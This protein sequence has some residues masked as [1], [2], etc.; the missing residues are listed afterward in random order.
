M[1]VEGVSRA[2]YGARGQEGGQDGGGLE[3]DTQGEPGE[4]AVGFNPA[5][6]WQSSLPHLAVSWLLGPSWKY[7]LP[8][9]SNS[10]K[11]EKKL[12]SSLPRR[13]G[14]QVD[15]EVRKPLPAPP[16]SKPPCPLP[17]SGILFLPTALIFLPSPL[18]GQAL[19]E[20]PGL[21]EGVLQLPAHPA[22]PDEGRSGLGWR[23]VPNTPLPGQPA[24]T[25]L[26]SLLPTLLLSLLV[27]WYKCNQSLP[28]KCCPPVR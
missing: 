3:G 21:G 17:P 26:L 28:C 12:L 27:N 24:V 18:L 9:S 1:E 5:Y 20:V 8:S 2:E 13:R 6:L 25:W 15:V 7:P 19:E 23:L 10:T 14:S 16:P 4:G 22:Q 11:G